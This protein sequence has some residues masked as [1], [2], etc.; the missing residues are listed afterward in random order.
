METLDLAVLAALNFVSVFFAVA[1]MAFM[2]RRRKRKIGNM[3]MEDLGRKAETDANF[4]QI[5]RK[6]FLE[7]GDDDE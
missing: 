7:E 5:I 4:A 3:I 1:S 2:D 6:N